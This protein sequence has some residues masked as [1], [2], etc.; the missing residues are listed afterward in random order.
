V[1]IIASKDIQS[2]LQDPFS[3]FQPSAPTSSTKRQKVKVGGGS[4]IIISKDGYI[5]TNK[6]VVSDA[7]AE[8]TVITDNGNIYATEKVRRD[9]ALDIAILKILDKNK[10]I[11]DDLVP[12]QFVSLNT[13]ISI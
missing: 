2:Y 5:I 8:Y 10:K 4:G 13:P 12:A 11:P 9:P 3:A 7:Q 1:S 6:H